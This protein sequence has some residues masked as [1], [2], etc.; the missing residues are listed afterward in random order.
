MAANNPQRK[1]ADVQ[2]SIAAL[3]MAVSL[4][5]W[6]LFAGSD[7][8]KEEQKQSQIPPTLPPTEVPVI[9]PTAVQ[10]MPPAGYTI[11]FGGQAPQPQVIV[12]QSHHGGNNN[13][14]GGGGNKPV[15]ST[16]SS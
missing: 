11:L 16:N 5:L 15:T 4:A 3:A 1:W 13:G 10:T 2:F 14:G 9:A 12:I 8:K 7:L 6:N